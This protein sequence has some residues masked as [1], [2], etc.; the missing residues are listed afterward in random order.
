NMVFDKVVYTSGDRVIIDVQ[1]A[2]PEGASAVSS[3]S[4]KVM[5]GTQTMWQEVRTSAQFDYDIP[6][7]FE[8]SLN[9][10][11][12]V[13]NADGDS[14]QD[15]ETKVVRHVVLLINAEP[16][17]YLAG[18]TITANYQ[19]ISNRLDENEERH[20]FY[21]VRDANNRI[22][23]E[24]EITGSAKTGN[25]QYQVPDV[26]STWYTFEVFANVVLKVGSYDYRV[27]ESAVDTVFLISGYDLEISVDN[28]AYS[29]GDRVTIHYTITPRGDEGLPD[30]F[31]FSYGMSNGQTFSWQSESPSGDIYY[32]IPSGVNEGDVDF[33][34]GAWDGD[35]N[36]I[37]GADE[38][39]RIQESPNPFEFVRL[40]DIPLISIILLIL[41]ILL[42][43]IMLF[44]RPSA[45]P[46]RE[47][48]E[49][50]PPAEEEAPPEEAEP[51]EEAGPLSINC[52][53]CGAAIDITTS[54]RPIEVMCPSCGETEMV[55]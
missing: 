8:G 24:G 30:K 28:P 34:V 14:G 9:F 48:P 29:P 39:L 26:A 19:L 20:F 11:V 40:G 53:S 41:V 45:A 16:Q 33:F 52:K 2:V 37:G 22:V 47:E 5:A 42:I 4:Y 32:D 36:W 21:V 3:Y 13:Y 27:L 54:K 25:F 43:I 1:T 6:D 44:R 10:R 46:P 49:L 7:N 35:W 17:E 31:M 18:Q 12:D 50:G 38:V 55:E 51:M 23:L 15:T